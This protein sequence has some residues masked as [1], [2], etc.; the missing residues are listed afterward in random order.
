MV[1]WVTL[2]RKRGEEKEKDLFSMSHLEYLFWVLRGWPSAHSALAD[3]RELWCGA[4][5]KLCHLKYRKGQD[6]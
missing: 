1:P 4:K 3:L 6:F 2:T 5:T